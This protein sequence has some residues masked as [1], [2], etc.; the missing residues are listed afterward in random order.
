[1][2]RRALRT[3]TRVDGLKNNAGGADGLAS[4]TTAG[5]S[6]TA[7]ANKARGDAGSAQMF[8]AAAS[9]WL[10]NEVDYMDG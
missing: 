2:R 4:M 3:R 6:S 8:A 1:M 10:A 7:S 9:E 5:R